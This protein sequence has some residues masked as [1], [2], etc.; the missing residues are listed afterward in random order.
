MNYALHKTCRY[1]V[2]NTAPLIPQLRPCL[3]FEG[4]FK[5]AANL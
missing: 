5:L 2:P 4:P 3:R 1:S